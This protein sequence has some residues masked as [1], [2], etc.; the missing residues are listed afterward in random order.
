MANASV[1]IAESLDIYCRKDDTFNLVLTVQNADT[2]NFDFTSYSATLNVKKHPSSD[3]N[4]LSFSS[5]AGLTLAT[6]SITLAKTAAQMD[7]EAGVYYYELNVTDASSNVN[8]WLTGDFIINSDKTNDITSSSTLTVDTTGSAVTL[9][10][11]GIAGIAAG[12]DTEL[13]YNNNGVFGGVSELTY[14]DSTGLLSYQPTLDEATGNEIALNLSYTVNKAT[15]GN[16]TGLLINQTDTASPGTSYLLDLQVGGTSQFNVANDGDVT[17]PNGDLTVSADTD[18]ITVLGRARFDSRITDIMYLS[19]VDLVSNSNYAFSQNS[20]G[21]TS[22]NTIGTGALRVANTAKVNWGSANLRPAVDNDLTLGAASFGWKDLYFASGGQIFDNS[23]AALTFDGSQNVTIPNGDLSI[24]DSA[25]LDFTYGRI[26]FGDGD[27]GVYEVSDDIIQFKT[28]GLDYWRLSANSF[29]CVQAVGAPE[30]SRTNGYTFFG[31]SNTY[32][33]WNSA[34]DI[35]LFTGG[36]EGLN[37]DASQNVS[38]P[39]GVLYLNSYTVAGLPAA[40]TAGG[41]IYV[42]DE[43]GGATMAFSDGTNWRRVQDR[44]IVS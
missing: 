42:S 1:E 18:A 22:L 25:G 33:K 35:S 6:G 38:I 24:G 10:I 39:N 31:D 5:G 28:A 9:T 23:I 36:V 13:Q 41:F 7:L 3:T 40:T 30:I 32:L 37:I 12:S 43:T 34:D 26:Y 44:A 19:H 15:S 27:T 11:S 20:T 16:D 21:S 4:I 29:Q 8:A 17:I 2:S 14:N